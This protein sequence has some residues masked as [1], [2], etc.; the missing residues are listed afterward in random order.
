MT[1][2]NDK[3]LL[4]V[5]PPEPPEMGWFMLTP[6]GPV[7]VDAADLPPLA[8]RVLKAKIHAIDTLHTLSQRLRRRVR[9]WLEGA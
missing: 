1:D 8:R 2:P 4:H 9:R 7:Y 6:D 3:P 5:V